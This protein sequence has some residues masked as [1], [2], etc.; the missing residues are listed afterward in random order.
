MGSKVSQSGQKNEG[1]FRM[2]KENPKNQNH[3]ARDCA[4]AWGISAAC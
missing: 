3:A 1:G 4:R 2:Q